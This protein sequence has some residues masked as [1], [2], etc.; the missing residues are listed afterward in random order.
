MNSG[1]FTYSDTEIVLGLFNWKIHLVGVLSC[2]KSLGACYFFGV[3]GSGI[4]IRMGLTLLSEMRV[5]IGF[6]AVVRDPV[7]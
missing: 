5:N 6:K 3:K 4:V 7:V 2:C 1:D